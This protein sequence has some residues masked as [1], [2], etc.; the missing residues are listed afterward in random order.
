LFALAI[1]VAA[2]ACSGASDLL[3]PAEEV[4]DLQL[5]PADMTLT[6][7]NS[8]FVTATGLNAEGAVLDGDVLWTSSDPAIATVSEVGLVTA[9]SVGEA[10]VMADF[11]GKGKAHGRKKKAAKV[12]VDDPPDPQIPPGEDPIPPPPQDTVPPPPQDT[13]PP[14]PQD[15]VPPPPQDTVPP[16][17]QDT[18]PPPPQDTVP[19]PPPPPPP[20]PQDGGFAFGA[21]RYDVT[22]DYPFNAALYHRVHAGREQEELDQLRDNGAVGWLNMVG[23]KGNYKNSDETFNVDMWKAVLDE[24]DIALIQAAVDD[25]TAIA[26]YVLD[27]PH[28]GSQWSGEDVDPALVDEAACYSKSKWPNLPVLIRTHPGWAV[29]EEGAAHDFQCVDLWVAQYSSRKGPVDEYVAEN[30]ADAATL[31]AGLFGTLN[32]ITGGDGSSGVPSPVSSSK[33]MMSAAE[34]R[35]Y[36]EA[37]VT[38]PSVLGLGAWYWGYGVPDSMEWYWFQPDIRASVEYLASLID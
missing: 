37:F 27:E 13:V 38:E 12:K 19:P 35:A 1:L 29:R 11:R 34:V 32:P 33:W 7:G 31:G 4:A 15:T 23:G 2:V 26:H 5:M 16:P 21:S 28:A 30:V 36:G 24:F 3:D 6:V 17:P 8:A 22:A 14:P 10:S 18:V 9:L 20:P 25:G